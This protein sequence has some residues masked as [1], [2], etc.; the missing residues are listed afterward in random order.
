[1]SKKKD[2]PAGSQPN[3]GDY[4]RLVVE[5]TP[6]AIVVVDDRGEISLANAQ[7]QR[8]FGYTAAELRGKPVDMLV[9]E[10][11]RK[12]HPAHRGSYLD[13]PTTRSMGAGRDLFGLCK[14]GREVPIEIGLNPITTPE[15]TFVLTSIVD[16][17]GRKHAEALRLADTELRV[18]DEE[19]QRYR[20]LAD[21]TQDIILFL[22]GDDL[23]IF[24]ANAA[25]LAAYGYERSQLIGKPL[26]MLKPVDVVVD[27]TIV[28]RTDNM[29]GGVFEMMHRRSDGTL[30]PVEIYARGAYVL[31]RHTL[32][33][34]A[35]DISERRAAAQQ[36]ALAL[37]QALEGSRLKGEFVATMSHEIRTPMHGVLAMSELLLE[38]PLGSLEREYAATLKESALAL[39]AIIDDILDFSKLEANKIE[40]ESVAFRPAD[41]V[42]GVVNLVRAAAGNKGLVLHAH[43]SPR[44]PAAVRGDPTRVRQ[45]LMNLVGNAV[46]FT[47][48]GSVT[49]ALSVDRDDGK[50]VVLSFAVSDTGIGVTQ[51][52]RERLFEPF[53]QADGSTTRKFGG[54]GLGLTISRR[55]VELLGGR[56]WLGEHEGPGATFCFTVR[57]ERAADGAADPQKPPDPSAVCDTIE[58]VRET[59]LPGAVEEPGPTRILVAEDSALI[60]RVARFQLQDL[61]YGFD[62]VE[63]GE[64]AVAAVANGDYELVLMDMRMPVMDGLAATR[65]IRAA[66]RAT[67]GHIIIVALTANVLESDRAACVEAGMDDFLPKPLELDALRAVLERWLPKRV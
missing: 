10:R 16:I 58:P 7:A 60:R 49:I 8:M 44:L 36:I 50:S 12:V 24:E 32:M 54:T 40:L 21:V 4:W 33:M 9:P 14:D 29:T 59:P 62:I 31:G 52:D 13:A 18:R 28:E 66:E 38:R 22:D 63:N 65:A 46:K 37:E 39:L 25:A 34:T 20:L 61:Q 17:T 57:C 53:V 2:A 43:V 5:A 42:D 47:D 48:R 1:M 19:L 64:Q 26:Q 41:V 56:I 3:D 30:F 67:G 15:G 11:Y 51:E 35:R 45:I 27:P 55:L 23:T 6:L